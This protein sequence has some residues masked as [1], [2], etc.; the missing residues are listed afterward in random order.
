MACHI[1]SRPDSQAREETQFRSWED[2]LKSYTVTHILCKQECVMTKNITLAID[3]SLLNEVRIIAAKK[4]M[5][6]NGLVRD[7]LKSLAEQEDK[8]LRT[9]YKL[10]ELMDRSTADMGPNWRWDRNKTHE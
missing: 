6:V 4:K 8:T 2:A 3:E 9:R 5:T 7:Y 10:L 1:L